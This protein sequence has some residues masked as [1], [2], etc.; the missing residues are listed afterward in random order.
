MT[1]FREKGYTG[2]IVHMYSTWGELGSQG[3]QM[4]TPGSSL[5]SR[6]LLTQLE[7]IGPVYPL[8]VYDCIRPLAPILRQRW[9]SLMYDVNWLARW[10]LFLRGSKYL[11]HIPG[12]EYF[13]NEMNNWKKHGTKIKPYVTDNEQLLTSTELKHECHSKRFKWDRPI[14]KKG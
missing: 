3:K 11:E 10:Q 13:R 1:L 14:L 12:T 8:Y 5:L 6:R 9:C 4:V 7:I 2:N